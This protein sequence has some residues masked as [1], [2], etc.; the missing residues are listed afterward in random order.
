MNTKNSTKSHMVRTAAILTLIMLFAALPVWPAGAVS[1]DITSVGSG[2]WEATA[3]PNTQRSGT[4]T[5]T[6]GSSTVIGTGTAFTAELSVGNIIKTNDVPP[7]PI[8]VVASIV[9]DTQLTLTTNSPTTWTGIDYLV[10]GV[11]PADNATI[12]SSHT[13]TIAA[14]AV[15]QT[16][17]VTV[18]TGGTLAV[19]NPGTVFDTLH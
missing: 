2:T 16:G 3:W 13:V 15:N 14:N 10:Q 5:V 4:I 19:S 7:V 6:S 12:D 9:S 18:N 1:L 8:G 17:I 11:G